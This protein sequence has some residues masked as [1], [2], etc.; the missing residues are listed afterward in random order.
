ML[1]DD[2]NLPPRTSPLAPKLLDM[3]TGGHRGPGTFSR[4][5]N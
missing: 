2:N 4:V 3:I 1:C 5:K